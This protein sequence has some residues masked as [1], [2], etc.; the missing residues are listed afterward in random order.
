L[1]GDSDVVRK[2]EEGPANPDQQSGRR[3]YKRRG[4]ETFVSAKIGL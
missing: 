4:A 2:T 3:H 1:K